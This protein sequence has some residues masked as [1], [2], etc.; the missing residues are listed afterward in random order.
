MILGMVVSPGLCDFVGLG[1]D[2]SGRAARYS[3]IA[4]IA[5]RWGEIVIVADGTKCAVTVMAAGQRLRGG[6]IK[7]VVRQRKPMSAIRS[8]A[9]VRST[10]SLAR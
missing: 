4:N 9:R 1:D 7:A 8:I 10:A 5:I 2:P 3:D 6:Y